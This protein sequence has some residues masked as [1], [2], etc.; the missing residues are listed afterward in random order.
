MFE[1]KS[2]GNENVLVEIF[3]ITGRKMGEKKVSSS[4]TK[5]NIS[6]LSPGFYSVVCYKNGGVSGIS[7]LI[8]N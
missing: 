3:D 8:K 5:I 4:K 1:M 7:K 2:I 6:N